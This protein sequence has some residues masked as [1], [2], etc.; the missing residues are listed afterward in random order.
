MDKSDGKSDGIQLRHIHVID[1]D[2]KQ[3][4]GIKDGY[5]NQA[6]EGSEVEIYRLVCKTQE[7][8]LYKC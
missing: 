8:S 3:I 1:P 7:E 4:N 6:Y 2:Q 5:V